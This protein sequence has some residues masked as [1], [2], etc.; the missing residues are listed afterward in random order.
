MPTMTELACLLFVV[1]LLVGYV[2]FLKAIA[3]PA[4]RREM[5]VRLHGDDE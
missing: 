2:A 1:S 5:G 4:D 3:S